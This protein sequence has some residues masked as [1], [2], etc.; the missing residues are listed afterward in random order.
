MMRVFHCS[1]FTHPQPRE[2]LTVVSQPPPSMHQAPSM[3]LEEKPCPA[4][5]QPHSPVKTMHTHSAETQQRGEERRGCV[6][7]S[8]PEFESL[9]RHG[10]FK[11][12]I[13][14]GNIRS[15]MRV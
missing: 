13:N 6:W 14:R 2:P 8:V 9:P 7:H 10:T 15:K 12:N 11:K 3:F 1:R 4:L 5:Q